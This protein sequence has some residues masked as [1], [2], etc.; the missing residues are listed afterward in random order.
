MVRSVDHH[1][2]ETIVVVHAKLRK[3]MKKVKSASV[4]DYEFEVYEVHK[5][6]NLTEHVP[7][8]VYDAENINRESE[9]LDEDM[10]ELSLPGAS[11]EK[12]KSPKDSPKGSPRASQDISR[13]SE[14]GS[15][16]THP[17]P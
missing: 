16:S 17:S 13:T 10:D 9:D 4:H 5:V 3:A 14:V 2:P 15:R 12:P 1:P 8:T 6:V 7:F 11:D